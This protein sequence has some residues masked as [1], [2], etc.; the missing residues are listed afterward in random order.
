MSEETLFAEA[1]ARSDPAE[2]AAFLE[3]A[4]GTTR[5]GQGTA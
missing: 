5:D 1:L 4:C 2:R 3:Q